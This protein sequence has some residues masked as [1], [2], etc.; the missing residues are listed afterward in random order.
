MKLI[1]SAYLPGSCEDQIRAYLYI[2]SKYSVNYRAP[3]DQIYGIII[4]VFYLLGTS[5]KRF[6]RPK[7]IT[8]EPRKFGLE[9][10]LRFASQKVVF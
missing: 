4:N 3:C 5:T 8:H 2:Y 7:K 9:S 6:Q 10:T 1:N